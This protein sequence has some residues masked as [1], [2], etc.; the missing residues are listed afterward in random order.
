MRATFDASVSRWNM[1]SPAKRPLM[2]IP[3]SPPARRFRSSHVS[4]LWAHPS[5]C[6][7]TYALWMSLVIHAPGRRRSAHAATT[8]PNAVLTETRYRAHDL[9]NERLTLRPSSGRIPRGLGDHHARTFPSMGIGNW[10]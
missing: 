6:R 1:D 8:S 3:Y 2:A 4:T 5:R 10:P 7:F 9:R